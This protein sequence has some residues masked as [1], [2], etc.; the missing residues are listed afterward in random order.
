MIVIIVTAIVILLLGILY[1][2]FK[3]Q[4][5]RKAEYYK[6][7][8]CNLHGRTGRAVMEAIRSSEPPDLTELRK[9]VEEFNKRMLEEEKK[10][11]DNE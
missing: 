7:N 4:F 9:E 2:I 6:P 5:E 10:V 8:M 3:K 1:F 11:N